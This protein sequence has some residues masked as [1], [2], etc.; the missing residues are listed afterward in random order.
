MG[1]DFSDLIPNSLTAKVTSALLV[2]G[3][4]RIPN[5]K[6]RVFLR[7][8]FYSLG[9]TMTLGLSKWRVTAGIWNK[10]CEPVF[11][12]LLDNIVYALKEG[13][14]KG[15]RTDDVVIAA[16]ATDKPDVKID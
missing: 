8:T 14:V 9:V 11:V 15:L 5:D 12:D 6:V 3:I 1:L 4:T 10:V 16:P 2:F 13:L 7:K